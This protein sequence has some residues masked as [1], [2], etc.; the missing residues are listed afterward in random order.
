MV[1]LAR[2]NRTRP[3]R[4]AAI[5]AAA[6]QFQSEPPSPSLV[7]WSD[8]STESISDAADAAP[9]GGDSRT[10]LEPPYCRSNAGHTV[11]DR[12]VVSKGPNSASFHIDELVDGD[13]GRL[14]VRSAVTVAHGKLWAT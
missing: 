6:I 10:R 4:A 2:T 8:P 13:I 11:A 3:S 14:R 12:A 1:R 7:V 9:F 5:Q